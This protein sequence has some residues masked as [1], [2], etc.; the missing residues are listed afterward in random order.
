LW[1][2]HSGETAVAYLENARAP[3]GGG[4]F[5][6]PDLLLLDLKMPGKS[7]FDVLTWLRAQPEYEHLP[8]V[9]LTSSTHEEDHAR[10]PALGAARFPA[11]PIDYDGLLSTVRSVDLLLGGAA[12]L[13]LNRLNPLLGGSPPLRSSNRGVEDENENEEACDLRT[14]KKPEF[15]RLF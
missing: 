2:V 12:G 14:T 1:C 13:S 15:I 11:K 9:V 4:E 3:S 7:G 5:P 10:A 6:L 8:V